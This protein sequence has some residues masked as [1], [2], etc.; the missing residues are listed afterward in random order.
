MKKVYILFGALVFSL[1]ALAQVTNICHEFAKGKNHNRQIHI[2]TKSLH[3]FGQKIL[4]MGFLQHGPTQQH[5]GNTE[6]LQL[7]LIKI[8]EL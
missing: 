7:L 8:Q 6:V 1:S 2:Q 3:H 5:H 4:Q